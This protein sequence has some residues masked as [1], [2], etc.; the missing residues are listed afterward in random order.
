MLRAYLCRV[1]SGRDGK[2]NTKVDF[3]VVKMYDT[4]E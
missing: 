2:D 3:K 4:S 1:K